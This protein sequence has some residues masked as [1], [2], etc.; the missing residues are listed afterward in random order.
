MQRVELHIRYYDKHLEGG[1]GHNLKQ[2]SI[3]RSVLPSHK[4]ITNFRFELQR[5]SKEI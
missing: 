5:I 4:N 1:V 2:G 3:L